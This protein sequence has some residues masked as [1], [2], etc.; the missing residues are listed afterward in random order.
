MT[1]I[2]RQ[3]ST[4]IESL[5]SSILGL[6]YDHEGWDNKENAKKT[7]K[8]GTMRHLRAHQQLFFLHTL[9]RATCPCLVLRG[10]I[11]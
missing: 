4:Q 7:N 6:V 10:F 9:G 11:L 5:N 2:R 1:Q 3:T 8:G